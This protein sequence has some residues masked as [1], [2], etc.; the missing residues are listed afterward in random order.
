MSDD[1][2]GYF[3]AWQ[4]FFG[5][6]DEPYVYK[7]FY[8][9]SGSFDSTNSPL[10]KGFAVIYSNAKYY[11]LFDGAS[12]QV[13]LDFGNGTLCFY[14]GG[15]LKVGDNIEYLKIMVYFNGE[16]ILSL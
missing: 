10:P 13:N 9:Y 1:P 15:Y 3:N 16:Q 4:R 11:P 12:Y 8:P 7:P 6:E 5:L 14:P 2:F